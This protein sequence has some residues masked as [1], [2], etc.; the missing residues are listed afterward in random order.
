MLDKLYAALQLL[1]EF[2]VAVHAAG[3]DEIGAG[4]LRAAWSR[5]RVGRPVAV[6]GVGSEDRFT[7]HDGHSCCLCWLVGVNYAS[8]AIGQQNADGVD[9]GGNTHHYVRDGVSVHVALLVHLRAGQGV[10]ILPLK[11]QNLRD[12]RGGGAC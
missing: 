7:G 11:L 6:S 12:G 8:A 2:E 4:H 3:D 10:Q 1:P 9:L 5:R